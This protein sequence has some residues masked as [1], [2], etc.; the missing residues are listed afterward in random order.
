MYVFTHIHKY[1]LIFRNVFYVKKVL[2]GTAK[3][4]LSVL[5]FSAFSV[6]FPHE[7]GTEIGSV[8]T[9]YYPELNQSV[10]FENHILMVS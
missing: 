1:F 9:L 5:N 3:M 8:F 2:A 7:N 4:T 6:G 10:Y